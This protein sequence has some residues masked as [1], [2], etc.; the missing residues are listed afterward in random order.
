[1]FGLVEFFVERVVAGLTAAVASPDEEGCK[2]L[3]LD[4]FDV[5]ASTALDGEFFHLIKEG[6]E[7]AFTSVL[8][9]L[10]LEVGNVDTLNSTFAQI[11]LSDPNVYLNLLRLQPLANRELGR[12]LLSEEFVELVDDFHRTI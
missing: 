3:L 12:F 2:A 7:P 8:L 9:L 5:D 10:D 4:A 1:M 11:A 6:C